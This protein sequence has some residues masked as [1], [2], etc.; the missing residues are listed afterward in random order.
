MVIDEYF[1]KFVIIMNENLDI[2]VILGKLY[3]VIVFLV[4]DK[5]DEVF[6][7]IKGIFLLSESCIKY[8]YMG[9]C[10]ICKIIEVVR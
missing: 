5:C 8:V 4:F 7:R 2:D 6:S 1:K 10:L 9:L 3:V